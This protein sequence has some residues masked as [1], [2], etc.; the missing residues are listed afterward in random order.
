MHMHMHTH[1]HAQAHTYSDTIAMNYYHIVIMKT[2]YLS[3]VSNMR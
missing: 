1:T 2:T 3:V